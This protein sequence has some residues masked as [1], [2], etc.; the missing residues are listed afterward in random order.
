MAFRT[1]KISQMTPKGANLEGSDLL[2][3]STLESGSYVTRSITG[4]E[5]IDAASGT[6]VTNIT[7]N[8]PLAT[9]GGTTPDLSISEADGSTDGYLTAV[10]WSTFNGKQ[11][12]LVSGT[13]IKTINSTSVL[14]SGNIAVQAPLT[15]TT[16]GTSGAATL[17]GATLNIPQYSG[18]GE[19]GIHASIPLGSGGIYSNIPF[20][21]S[22]V[23]FTSVAN[24]MFL[25]PFIPNVTFTTANIFFN[26]TSAALTTNARILI[27]SHSSTT[28]LP[29]TK[30]FESTDIS[31]GSTGIKTL[32]TSQT[33]TKGVVYWLGYYTNGTSIISAAAAAT[34]L[35]IGMDSVL[36]AYNS[37]QLA[38]TFGSAP[39][40]FGSSATKNTGNFIRIGL[41][42]A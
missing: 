4:Q 30:L 17:V 34:Q 25:M 16:T 12:A 36:T 24:Q 38:A 29:N 8:A 20:G 22:S 31:V 10:D 1:Q 14:G 42:S 41:T 33:F 13:N 3:V 23:T 28:G 37:V 11:A 40:S 15:L 7:V 26:V 2:E 21:S 5:I 19:S 35:Q 27:Y 39:A 32:I 9:T 6:G 18:G